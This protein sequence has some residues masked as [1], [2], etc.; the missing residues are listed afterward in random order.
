M[1]LLVWMKQEIDLLPSLEIH[2]DNF[3]H[4]V[5]D[6]LITSFASLLRR[7]MPESMFV[8]RFGGDEFIGIMDDTN[9]CEINH[10]I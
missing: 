6:A 1:L 3:G 10:C 9:E 8:G 4:F 5:G 7:Y 2:N